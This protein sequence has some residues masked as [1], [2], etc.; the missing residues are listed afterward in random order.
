MFTEAARSGGYLNA[1]I[2]PTCFVELYRSKTHMKHTFLFVFARAHAH[3]HEERREKE[4]LMKLIKCIQQL[5]VN[6]LKNVI[7]ENNLSST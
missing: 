5:S 6:N 2:V 1:S 7:D 4:K 3:V